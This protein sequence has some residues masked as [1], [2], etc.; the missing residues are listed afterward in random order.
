[1]AAKGA[2][3]AVGH[4]SRLLSRERLLRRM[5][6]LE[7]GTRGI[8]VTMCPPGSEFGPD[9]DW[10]PQQARRSQAGLALVEY[11]TDSSARL[12]VA[13][14]F[15][16]L[17]PVSGPGMAAL[18]DLLAEPRTVGI[19]LLRFGHYAVGV[20]H[21]ETLLVT[22]S[23]SRYVKGGHRAG[24]QSANR[25]RRNREKWIREFFDEACG[26]AQARFEQS[27]RRIDWLALGGDKHTVGRFLKRCPALSDLADRTTP[28]W[29]PTHRPGRGELDE[30]VRFIWSSTVYE[31]A[32]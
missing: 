10:L 27:E 9:W 32:G 13:P 1:M 16:I 22:K 31:Q 12:A 17:E 28:S 20:A 24:G 8:S 15:P 29:V 14:P 26:V 21:D 4:R 5:D 25:F 19:V 18:E 6:Y 2:Q 11:G 30:A 3:A 7:T 23:G